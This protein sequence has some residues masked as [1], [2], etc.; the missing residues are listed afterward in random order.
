MLHQS[1]YYLKPEEP[2]QV[3]PLISTL[4][5]Q[6]TDPVVV[7]LEAADVGLGV[8]EDTDELKSVS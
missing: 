2:P 4:R 6:L 1:E 7:W 5:A 8:E 3:A